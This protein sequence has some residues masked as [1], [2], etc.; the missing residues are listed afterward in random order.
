ME[1]SEVHN[2][3]EGLRPL[4]VPIGDLNLDPENVRLHDERNLRAVRNSLETFGQHHPVVVQKDNMVVR[5]G[6]AR[7]QSARDLGWTH[8]AAL[9]VDEGRVE[10]MARAIADNRTGELSAW[11]FEGLGDQLT[12]LTEEGFDTDLVGFSDFE[13]QTEVEVETSQEPEEEDDESEEAS[14]YSKKANSPIYEPKMASPPAVSDLY[15]DRKVR[16]LL[17][18]IHAHALPLDVRAFLEVAAR[19]HAVLDFAKIAEFYA[20]AEAPVQR[21]M[22]SSALVLIDMGSAIE[23]GFVRLNDRLKKQFLEEMRSEDAE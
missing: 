6:N 11:D 23:N 1:T 7:L 17:A 10:A 4:L 19:R 21:L 2:V 3:L 16:D 8:I 18:Q 14:P 5:I 22:E 13:R 20:H 12:A 15:D 9:V